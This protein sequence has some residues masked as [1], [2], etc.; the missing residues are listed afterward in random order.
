MK[1]PIDTAASGSAAAASTT[2][3]TSAQ[4]PAEV[5]HQEPSTGGSYTRNV[6]TGE[7]VPA[8]LVPV[9]PVQE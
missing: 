1:N 7:L 9:N 5:Q 3:Q 6:E 4:Q 8:G 2:V